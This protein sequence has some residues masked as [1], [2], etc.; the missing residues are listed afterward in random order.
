MS[1]KPSSW[2]PSRERA[3]A[4]LQQHRFIAAVLER[5]GCLHVH[6]RT[7]ARGIAVGVFVGLTPTVGV[8][9]VLMLAGCLLIRG[10]FPA[11]FVVSW[12]SNPITLAPLYFGFNEL[13]E[14]VFDGIIGPEITISDRAD[15]AAVGALYLVLGSLLIAGPVAIAA[16]IAF[17]WVWRYL[18]LRKRRRSLAARRRRDEAAS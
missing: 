2:L 6:R 15:E 5:T 16:Y 12:V 1:W 18:M 11:A 17:I 13:G 3:H 4:W 7:L 14:A 9:T 8:Q 10:N